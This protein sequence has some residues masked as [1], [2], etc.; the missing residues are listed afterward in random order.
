MAEQPLPG[1]AIR[2]ALQSC[3]H[4]RNHACQATSGQDN[5]PRQPL[6]LA[7]IGYSIR[8]ERTRETKLG[9]CGST[10]LAGGGSVYPF[11]RVAAAS[12][13]QPEDLAA[14]KILFP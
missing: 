1:Q 4:I 7:L 13:Y 6:A 3:R 9:V 5:D 8:G 11:V 14:R 12:C 10:L 2:I